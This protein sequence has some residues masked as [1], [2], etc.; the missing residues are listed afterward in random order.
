MAVPAKP[1]KG[2]ART[3]SQTSKERNND[4]MLKL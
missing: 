1:C 2:T 3:I 4:C